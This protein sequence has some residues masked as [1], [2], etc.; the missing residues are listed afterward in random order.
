MTSL[1]AAGSNFYTVRQLLELCV[2]ALTGK[3]NRMA[4]EPVDVK[5]RV[6]TMELNFEY[7]IDAWIRPH[8]RELDMM[9]TTCFHIKAEHVPNDK[10]WGG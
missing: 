1:V 4:A 5:G 2:K 6:V 3:Q 8:L 10:V 7:D 9:L